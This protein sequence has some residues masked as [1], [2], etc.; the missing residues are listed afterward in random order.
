MFMISEKRFLSSDY[1]FVIIIN[2]IWDEFLFVWKSTFINRS[3]LKNQKAMV[4]KILTTQQFNL[5]QQLRLQILFY[6]HKY[7][8]YYYYFKSHNFIVGYS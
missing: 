2:N 6:Y 8:Y 1:N 5:F 7:K 3:L 4:I